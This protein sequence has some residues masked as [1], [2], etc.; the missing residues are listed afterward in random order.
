MAKIMKRMKHKYL[1]DC[2]AVW[3]LLLA[4][5][6]GILSE[7][8]IVFFAVMAAAYIALGFLLACLGDSIP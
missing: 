3:P 6:A 7:S 4:G 8:F 1:Y 5:V 2:L